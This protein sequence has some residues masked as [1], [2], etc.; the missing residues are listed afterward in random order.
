[1]RSTAAKRVWSLLAGIAVVAVGLAGRPALHAALP[2]GQGTPTFA[3]DIAP[4]LQRS[5]QNC[6]RPDGVAPMS[7]VTYEEVRPFARSIK[8]RISIG[9]HRGVMPPWHVEKNVGIQKYKNDPSLSDAEVAM[10]G[11]WVD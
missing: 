4:I 1:M 2:D 3:H 10:I 9:P 5:C 7:L 6:H 11:K 8:Q